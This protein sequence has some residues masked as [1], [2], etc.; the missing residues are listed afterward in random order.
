MRRL[1]VGGVARF[2]G[3]KVE[4]RTELSVEAAK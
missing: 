4:S 3:S 1:G 2:V